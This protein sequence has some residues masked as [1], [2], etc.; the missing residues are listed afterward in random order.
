MDVNTCVRTQKT[1]QSA[2]AYQG[3]TRKT[4]HAQVIF[5]VNTSVGVVTFKEQVRFMTY[6]V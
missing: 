5:R 3:I 4:R 2:T 1:E 6:T